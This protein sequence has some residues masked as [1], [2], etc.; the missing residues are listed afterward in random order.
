MLLSRLMRLLLDYGLG[1]RSLVIGS[2][3]QGRLLR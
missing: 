3:D 1:R 2:A